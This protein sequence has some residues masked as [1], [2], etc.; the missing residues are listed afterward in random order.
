MQITCI[1]LQGITDNYNLLILLLIQYFGQRPFS[2]LSIEL[3]VKELY[4]FNN[5]PYGINLNIIIIC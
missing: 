4:V 3:R 5:F 2:G 1:L